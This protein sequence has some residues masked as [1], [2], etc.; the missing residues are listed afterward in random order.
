MNQ[1]AH[2]MVRKTIEIDTDTA[3]EIQQLADKSN[4]SFSYMG[5]VLLQQAIKERNRK[6]KSVPNGN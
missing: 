3:I 4:W 6:R 5:Y 2:E 1:S